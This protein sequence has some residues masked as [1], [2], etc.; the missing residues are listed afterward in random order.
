MNRLSQSLLAGFSISVLV[1]IAAPAMVAAQEA[2]PEAE[3][4]QS[5]MQG[6]RLHMSAIRAVLAG[7]AP[8]GQGLGNPVRDGSVRAGGP[9]RRR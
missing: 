7:A 8:A 4:R 3:Y 1:G 6:F 9:G 2:S 5:I